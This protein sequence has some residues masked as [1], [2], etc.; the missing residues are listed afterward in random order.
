MKGAL[1]FL[2]VFFIVTVVSL[3]YSDLPPGLQIY[4]AIGGLDIDYPILGIEVATLVPACFNGIV[5]GVIVWVLYS[6][7]LGRKPEKVEVKV[8]VKPVESEVKP[9][10][11][12]VEPT[13]ERVSG[14]ISRIKIGPS[15]AKRLTDAGV[16]TINDLLVSGATREGRKELAAKTG[17]S[18]KLILEWVNLADLTR[19]KGIGEEFSD[20]LE[21]AGVDT[22]VE[23]SRR[24]PVNLHAKIQEVNEEKKLVRRLPTL[25]EITQWIEQAKTLPRQVE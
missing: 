1:V 2:A 20:L 7:T 15:Y 17:I 6:V 11:P 16:R 25:D 10:E 21:E 23:L 5:Y 14:S 4:E 8:E 9:E 18:E 12:K 24:N 19:I 22:V 13:E 3:G